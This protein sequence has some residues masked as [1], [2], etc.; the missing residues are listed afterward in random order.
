MEPSLER[1]QA[2]NGQLLHLRVRVVTDASRPYRVV[3]AH[4]GTASFQTVPEC[5]NRPFGEDVVQTFADDVH[6]RVCPEC[7]GLAVRERFE[8]HEELVFRYAAGHEPPVA[9]ENVASDSFHFHAVTFQ[10]VGHHAP[11]VALHGSRVESLS[12]DEQPEQDHQEADDLVSRYDF[13]SFKET[14]HIVSL[15]YILMYTYLLLIRT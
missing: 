2:E 15:Y 6:Q 4:A 5:L 12:Q 10:P 13:F 14:T 1:A 9:A 8:V 7:V 3:A 11:V